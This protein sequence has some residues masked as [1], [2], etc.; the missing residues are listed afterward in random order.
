[1]VHKSRS[2]NYLVNSKNNI[3]PSKRIVSTLPKTDI[4]EKS[5]KQPEELRRKISKINDAVK[6]LECSL[7]ESK[8]H[9]RQLLLNTHGEKVKNQKLAYELEEARKEN[10]QLLSKF[11]FPILK[12]LIFIK[13]KMLDV[14]QQQCSDP[15]QVSRSASRSQL[16]RTSSYSSISMVHLQYKYEELL[17]SHEGLLKVL[18]SKIKES[19]KC[20]RENDSLRDELQTFMMQISNSE[21]TIETLCNKYLNLRE[22][23]DR[24]IANLRYERDTL[25]LVHNQLVQLLHK[26]CMDEDRL[27]TAVVVEEME[28]GQI[29][30]LVLEQADNEEDGEEEDDEKEEE[31]ISHFNQKMPWLWTLMGTES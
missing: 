4:V 6:N 13:K 12:E 14:L 23:K 3:P 19:Q 30:D 7:L 26:K 5:K 8:Q 31:T 20:C 21:K 10:K 11:E 29:S 18:E 16:D 2:E 9:D 22:R 28:D 27:L 25:R 24:K 1:M 15:D 17:A